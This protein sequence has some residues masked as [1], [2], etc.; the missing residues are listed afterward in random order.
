MRFIKKKQQ[1][2]SLIETKKT[3]P[4]PKYLEL[5]TEVKD[6][7]RTNL[8]DEQGHIC[9]YCMQ[10]IKSNAM[11]IEHYQSRS[12][13][14]ELQLEFKNML[15]SCEGQILTSQGFILHCD[16]AKGEK[17]LEFINLHE[18]SKI[19]ILKDLKYRGGGEIE[20]S[21]EQIQHEI[22]EIL[23]LNLEQLK[24]MRKG[25]I[26]A[27]VEIMK[28]QSKKGD[29]KRNFLLGKIEEYQTPKEG[30]LK[31]FCQVRIYHLEKWLKKLP[32]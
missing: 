26:D 22:D 29:I 32:K 30:K 14:P 8:L 5:D 16:S 27:L 23:N 4:L 12:S 13:F 10:R 9:C 24:L 20:S 19:H 2:Q 17:E 25:V 18:K 21:N 15:A 3:I 1:P 11:K 31:P 7:I 28:K 6:D